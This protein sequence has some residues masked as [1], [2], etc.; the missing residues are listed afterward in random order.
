M[1]KCQLRN[2]SISPRPRRGGPPPPLPG[3]RGLRGDR[4]PARAAP[5]LDGQLQ[6]VQ[7]PGA[8]A[9]GGLGGPQRPRKCR[10]QLGF[11]WDS[12]APPEEL[13]IYVTL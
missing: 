12:E 8:W 4:H 9:G 10:A 5:G 2:P 13:T 11:L 7:N 3:P 1:T 6:N